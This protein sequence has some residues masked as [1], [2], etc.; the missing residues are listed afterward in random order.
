MADETTQA[1]YDSMAGDSL[2]VTLLPEYRGR[3]NV[4][5]G[6][7]V[8]PDAPRPYIW[9]WGD[10]TNLP[11][12]TKDIIGR[13]VTRDIWI[14]ADDTGSEVEVMDIANRV[15]DLF[16]RLVMTIGAANLVTIVNGPRVGASTEDLTARIVTVD[17]TYQFS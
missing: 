13:E 17:F 11:F 9:S 5:T 12:D 7:T 8:P 10:I 6:R 3:I 2:L 1:I 15:R 14:V 4:H 16:N